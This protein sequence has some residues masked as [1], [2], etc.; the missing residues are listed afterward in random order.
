LH[1]EQINNLYS[2]P[3]IIREKKVEE[4][5]MGRYSAHRTDAVQNPEEKSPLGRPGEDGRI[6]LK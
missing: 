5:K 3:H 2:S 1:N 6:I 4:G